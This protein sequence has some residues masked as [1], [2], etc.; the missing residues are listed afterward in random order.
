MVRGLI[1]ERSY[2]WAEPPGLNDSATDAIGQVS[3]RAQL[4]TRISGT[5][6]G[7]GFV[8]RW[9]N[10]ADIITLQRT[11]VHRILIAE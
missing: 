1:S 10:H 9:H 8:P 11:K 5:R 2:P 3:S 6:M 4:S 7:R